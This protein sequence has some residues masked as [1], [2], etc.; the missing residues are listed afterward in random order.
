MAQ[1]QILGIPP[2]KPHGDQKTV[3]HRW[4]DWKKSF[5]YFIIASGIRD[6]ARQ[7]VILLHLLGPETQRIFD[8]LTPEDHR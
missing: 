2:F 1:L 8:T 6:N 5:S 7:K 3:A 4:N